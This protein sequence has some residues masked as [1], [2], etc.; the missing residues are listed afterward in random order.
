MG[1]ANQG[2]VFSSEL[3]VPLLCGRLRTCNTFEGAS[4]PMC[5]PKLH[6]RTRLNPHSCIARFVSAEQEILHAGARWGAGR[7][8]DQHRSPYAMN[9][10]ALSG[11]K[12]GGSVNLLHTS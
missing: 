11:R 6:R 4:P 2:T 10:Q 9:T 7:A 3:D 12:L 1:A 5:A 8:C